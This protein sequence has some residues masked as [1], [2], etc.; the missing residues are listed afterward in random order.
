M[1]SGGQS[2]LP[3]VPGTSLVRHRPVTRD[4]PMEL[5]PEGG[6]GGNR[7]DTL[8]AETDGADLLVRLKRKG[9]GARQAKLSGRGQRAPRERET[10]L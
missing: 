2:P 6:G 5:L 1:E 9:L 8:A 10:E 4:R 7:A 3:S